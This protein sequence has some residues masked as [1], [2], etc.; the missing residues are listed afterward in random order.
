MYEE[1]QRLYLLSLEEWKGSEGPDRALLCFHTKFDAWQ[2][3][4]PARI[5]WTQV[6]AFCDIAAEQQFPFRFVSGQLARQSKELFLIG[7]RSAGDAALPPPPPAW[8]ALAA[9]DR[10]E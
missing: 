3:S 9:V 4:E 7:L 8:L 6:L 10:Q 5:L 1:L 2:L